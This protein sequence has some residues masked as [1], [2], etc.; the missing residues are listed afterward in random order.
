MRV[1]NTPANNPSHWI[2]GGDTFMTIVQ[3]EVGFL[4]DFYSSKAQKPAT[5]HH[6]GAFFTFCD[7]ALGCPLEVDFG[8]PNYQFWV[9]KTYEDR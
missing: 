6:F 2:S 5:L 1:P 4:F 8:T 9:P 7:F 3:T